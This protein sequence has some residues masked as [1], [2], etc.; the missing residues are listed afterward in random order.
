MAEYSCPIATVFSPS[1]STMC[2]ASSDGNFTA[3]TSGG[4]GGCGLPRALDAGLL[5]LFPSPANFVSSPGGCLNDSQSN[6][7]FS[8]G[9]SISGGRSPSSL[10]CC[11]AAAVSPTMSPSD[12]SSRIDEVIPN[13]LY[14][15]SHRGVCDVEA[16]RSRDIR[17]FLC[18]AVEVDP[19]M[20]PFVTNDDI[21]SGAVSCKHLK[22]TDSAATRLAEHI[23]EATTFIDAQIALG[24]NVVVYCQQGKSRS[25]SIVIAY[26]MRAYKFTFDMALRK[27]QSAR[28][29]CDPN[30]CFMLQLAELDQVVNSPKRTTNKPIGTMLFNTTLSI[31]SS[32]TASRTTSRAPSPSCGSRSSSRLEDD[33]FS[34]TFEFKQFNCA[35]TATPS[36]LLARDVTRSP[37]NPRRRTRCADDLEGMRQAAA[38]DMDHPLLPPSSSLP[39]Y[40]RGGDAEPWSP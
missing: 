23:D 6:Q 8:G 12:D 26:L 13:A 22:L 24:R 15:S 18:V 29:V 17:A 33:C 31:D 16:V 40:P 39:M 36:Y 3:S 19:P 21:R 37:P 1:V 28:P 2:V 4:G 27:V 35:P 10:P 30:V 5:T 7:L 9:A 38:D 20:P 34:R 32:A 14:I 25:A 11:T